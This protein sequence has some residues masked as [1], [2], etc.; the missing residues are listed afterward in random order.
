[1]GQVS[2]AGGL[3]AGP[4]GAGEGTFP[5]TNVNTPLAFQT[6]PKAF[7]NASGMLTRVLT[8]DAVFVELGPVGRDVPR[9]NTLYIKG[10][11]SYQLRVTFDQTPDPDLVVTLPVQGLHISEYQ[12][13]QYVK[14]VEVAGELS[15]EYFVSGPT[16]P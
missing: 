11:G 8:N 5:G 15:I 10:N 14:K 12:D 13:A 7:Q 3:V 1:M 2:L 16:A 6:D 9:V 4:P